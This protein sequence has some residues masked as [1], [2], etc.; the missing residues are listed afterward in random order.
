MFM[1][2]VLIEFKLIMLLQIVEMMETVTY[3]RCTDLFFLRI[4]WFANSLEY[5]LQMWTLWLC[6]QCKYR[7]TA[8]PLGPGIPLSPGTP[9]SPCVG[10]ATW[11]REVRRILWFHSNLFICWYEK[12]AVIL[13]YHLT[14]NANQIHTGIPGSPEGPGSPGF[15]GSPWCKR[16]ERN[17][18]HHL[19]CNHFSFLGE[20]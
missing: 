5:Q 18:K 16:P 14:G 7:L 6:W 17:F 20:K 3:V 4:D 11:C 10:T 1:F 2:L 19:H 8:A 15:P 9:I 13:R 12:E